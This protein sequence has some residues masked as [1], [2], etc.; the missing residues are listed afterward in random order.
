MISE[1]QFIN[2]ANDFWGGILMKRKWLL[3]VA[4]F[5]II[6]LGTGLYY[7]IIKAGIPYQ[8]P[9]QE[10]LEQYIRDARIGELLTLS[11]MCIEVICALGFLAKVILKKRKRIL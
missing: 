3:Y 4:V 6:V 5:G 10:M 8:D 1:N 7:S 11:G 2:I 9:T